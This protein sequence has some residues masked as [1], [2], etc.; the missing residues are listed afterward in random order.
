MR[1]LI[2]ILIF[3]SFVCVSFF[4]LQYKL[5]H[6]Y[7]D[8][9]QAVWYNFDTPLNDDDNMG[10]YSCPQVGMR[11]IDRMY[12]MHCMYVCMYVSEWVILSF[13]IQFMAL[14]GKYTKFLFDLS[15]D[16]NERNNLYFNDKY[17]DVKVGRR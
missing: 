6:V 1:D 16:P 3:L 13:Q 2:F 10:S 15:A 5:A 12:C 17:S 9:P 4:R 14:M 11:R 7:T 8:N